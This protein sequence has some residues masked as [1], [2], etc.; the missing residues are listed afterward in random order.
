MLLE[1]SNALGVSHHRPA[2]VSQRDI[3]SLDTSRSAIFELIPMSP[4][5]MKLSVGLRPRSGVLVVVAA[6]GS[7]G[8]CRALCHRR[9]HRDIHGRKVRAAGWLN[10]GS[11]SFLSSAALAAAIAP[12]ACCANHYNSDLLAASLGQI[13]QTCGAR[14]PEALEHRESPA[15]R[16]VRA[17]LERFL[18]ML[19]LIRRYLAA[20]RA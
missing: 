8:G 14:I 12:L 11:S 20:R 3:D 9:S 4:K 6:S 13:P 7:D 19:A 2:P 16:E 10:H 17:T 15:G 1:R 18:E 5:L